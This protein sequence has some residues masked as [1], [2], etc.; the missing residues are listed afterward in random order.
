MVDSARI[1]SAKGRRRSSGSCASSGPEGH[2]GGELERAP[3]GC[4]GFGSSQ[5]RA[6]ANPAARS[7]AS[8]SSGPAKFHIPVIAV[9]CSENSGRAATAAIA[10]A[11]SGDVALAAALGDQAAA[12]PQ[13]RAQA[14]E[15]AV[16]VGIQWK[17]AVE[18]IR[19]TGSSTSSSERS[20]TR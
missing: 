13:R 20:A 9:K 15:E 2:G 4:T 3:A 11:C 10:W 16:V 6:S 19:S 18:K 8:V 7:R 12:R 1:A 17:V 14:L 5:Q